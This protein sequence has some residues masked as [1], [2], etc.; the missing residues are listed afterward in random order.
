[1]MRF[2]TPYSWWGGY[3]PRVQLGYVSLNIPRLKHIYLSPPTAR[4]YREVCSY[5]QTRSK[6]TD[7]V[8]FFP[9]LAIFNVLTERTNSC[10]VPIAFFDVCPDAAALQAAEYL[11][12][13]KPQLIVWMQLQENVWTTHE[14]MYR[15]GKPSGQRQIAAAIEALKA[16]GDYV[17]V[18]QSHDVGG[19]DPVEILM[20]KADAPAP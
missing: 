7:E 10:F 19:Y 18:Y 16:R 13:K 17:V 15:E 1:M 8:Y 20:R 12:S 2:T 9:H 6:P 11:Q 5:I 14:K 4:L 3:E